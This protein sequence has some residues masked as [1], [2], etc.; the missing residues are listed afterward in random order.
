MDNYQQT[1]NFFNED[2][3]EPIYKRSRSIK[4]NEKQRILSRGKSS[5]QKKWHDK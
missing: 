4:N 1:V 2:A 5:T 3:F